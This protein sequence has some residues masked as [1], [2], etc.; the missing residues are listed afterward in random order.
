[1][2]ADFVVDDTDLTR[3]DIELLFPDPDAVQHLDASATMAD[4]L[5]QLG[6]YSSKSQARKNWK[7][8]IDIPEG[9][10]SWSQVGK[11]R[12]TISTHKVP[13]NFRFTLEQLESAS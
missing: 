4:V 8:E 1:V 2:H 3:R 12:V 10:N 7:H 6:I 11:M 13:R 5:V 9:F